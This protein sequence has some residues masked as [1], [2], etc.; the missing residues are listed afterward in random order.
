MRRYMAIGLAFFSVIVLLALLFIWDINRFKP[1]VA[2]SVERELGLKVRIDGSL[3][4]Q[5]RPGLRFVAR[6]LLVVHDGV[7]LRLDWLALNPNL[8]SVLFNP[9]TASRWRMDWI[10]VGDVKVDVPEAGDSLKIDWK[11]APTF[12]FGRRAIAN[13]N[14]LYQGNESPPIRAS[15]FSTVEVSQ[16]QIIVDRSELGCDGLKLQV[17][18]SYRFSDRQTN[19][20]AAIALGGADPQILSSCSGQPSDL[21]CNFQP[22]CQSLAQCIGDFGVVTGRAT[23]AL[24]KALTV[25]GLGST[26]RRLLF[27][28]CA[29]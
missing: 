11:A 7:T 26:D 13:A 28:F 1:T 25:G 22:T 14:V 21:Q 12:R 5:L 29:S 4:W 6:N 2:A 8:A 16:H 17:N 27:G 18:G 3:K 19:L 15:L 9:G 20:Q 23:F 24:L 10:Q